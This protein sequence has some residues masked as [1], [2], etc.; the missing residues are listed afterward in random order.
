MISLKYCYCSRIASKYR[1]KMKKN[2]LKTLQQLVVKNQE[3]AEGQQRIADEEQEKRRSDENRK[4][5][6][7]AK[8]KAKPRKKIQKEAIKMRSWMLRN[9]IL[10]GNAW[11]L[12]DLCSRSI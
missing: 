5:N 3:F 6:E 12:E 2:P 4:I 7:K 9:G 10:L 8:K 1:Q 11:T